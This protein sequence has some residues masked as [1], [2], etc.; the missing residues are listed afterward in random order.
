M[1][2]AHPSYHA[3]FRAGVVALVVTAMLAVIQIDSSARASANSTQGVTKDSIKI[4][5][6]IIDYDSIKD[7]LDYN[8]G[9]QRA[10]AQSF[11]DDINAHGGI[12]GR[13]IIPVFKEYPPI[14]G[15]EPDPLS[16]C[17]SW[18]EDDKVFAV[19]GVFIDFTGQGILCLTREHHIIHIGHELDQPWIDQSP[20][21]VLLTPDNTKEAAAAV[22]VDLLASNGRLKGKTVAVLASKNGEPRATKTVIPALEKHKVKL[23]STAILT[24]TG[25]ETEAVR[26]QVDAFIERWKSEKVDTVFLS[27]L[28]VSSKSYVS[29][30]KHALPDV[31]LVTDADSTLEQARDEVA[32]G[33]DPNPYD[34]MISTTGLTFSERWAKK[35]P[36]L[37]QCVD[38]YEKA[39]GKK[40][41]GPDAEVTNA[42]GKKVQTDV[43]VMD[44]CGELSMFRTIAEKVGRDLTLKRWQ[45]AVDDFGP[46]DLVST[47]FASLCKGK[48]SANDAFRLVAFD[49]SAGSSGDWKRLTPVKDANRGACTNAG[50]KGS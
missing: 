29:Q 5:I 44:F 35:S 9:D 24:L 39:S 25:P 3:A 40:V 47:P 46:I 48:Y 8:H 13:K 22:L 14:P 30:I 37:Q 28:D 38:V 23:G 6:A 11:V 49:P 36:L 32:A 20:G 16:L 19:L 4:G 31:T 26:S 12:A 41:P 1:G 21:G 45:K 33:S 2:M 50:T 10:V 18:A 15:R 43:A 34:G 42:D 17:T 27:G 7:F